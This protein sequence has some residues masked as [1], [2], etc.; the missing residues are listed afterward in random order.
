MVVLSSYALLDVNDG[1]FSW[2]TIAATGAG[3]CLAGA[4]YR[5]RIPV[6]IG[7]LQIAVALI[8]IIALS[9]RAIAV[10]TWLVLAVIG[11]TLVLLSSVAE[12]YGIPLSRVRRLM[13]GRSDG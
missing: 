11:I 13:R 7:A 10:D 4:H 3:L 6:V 2:L 9:M 8:A 12:R 5:E 1:M